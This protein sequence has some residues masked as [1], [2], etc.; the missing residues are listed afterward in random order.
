MYQKLQSLGWITIVA[1]EI[2]QNV[3]SNSEVA[4]NIEMTQEFH[5]FEFECYF[6]DKPQS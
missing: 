4:P 3:T 2:F 1:N 5:K 6:C